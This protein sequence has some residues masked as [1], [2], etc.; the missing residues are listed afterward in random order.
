MK[1]YSDDAPIPVKLQE[2]P[3][4]ISARLGMAIPV[5]VVVAVAAAYSN[6]IWSPFVLDDLP[7]ITGNSSI[8]QW[9]TALAA[10]VQSSTQGRPALNLSFALNYWIS[11]YSVWSYHVLNLLIHTACALVLYGIVRRTL[12]RSLGAAAVPIAGSVALLWSVHPLNT[13]AVTYTVQRAESLMGLLMLLTVYCFIRFADGDSRRHWVFGV[14]SVVSCFLGMATKEVMVAAPLIVW[15]YDRAFVAGS[16]QSALRVRRGYYCSLAASWIVL[17]ILVFNGDGRGGTAGLGNGV[18]SWSYCITQA[19]AIVHYLRL[20]FYP[21]PLIFYYGEGLITD[22]LRVV[23]EAILLIGLLAATVLALRM[24]PALGFLGASFFLVLAPSSSFV[25]VV[26]ETAAEHRMYLALVPVV[27][28]GVLAIYR[29]FGSLGL[30]V[31]PALALCLGVMTHARNQAYDSALRLWSTTVRDDPGNP[32]AHNNLGCELDAI[33]GRTR[34]AMA[35]FETAIRLRPEH[36]E[37]H[38]NLANDLRLIPG[39]RNE[40]IAEFEA[41]L[42][43]NPDFPKAHNNLAAMLVGDPGRFGDSIHHYREAIRL[44]P[45]YAEAHFNLGNAW[46]MAQGRERDAVAEYTIALQLRPDYAEAHNN[47]SKILENNPA[48]QSEAIAHLVEAIRI[49]PGYTEAQYNLGTELSTIPGRT[50]EAIAHLREAIRLKSDYAEAR[51]NLA[52]LW[53]NIPEHWEEAIAQYRMA[54]EIQPGYPE[55]HYNLAAALLMRPGHEDEARSQLQAFLKLDP[56]NTQAQRLLESIGGPT[57][58]K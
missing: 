37:A 39:R 52:N 36:A 29:L 17:G 38:Y 35:E 32:W 33:P 28:L 30:L 24:S 22:P 51:N 23:P 6:T 13:E 8:R 2:P 50:D 27:V 41:A 16:F 15:L 25:P 46:S 49:N 47:L 4:R 11:G 5:L 20:C 10:P 7:S 44:Y 57:T 26:T 42:R 58:E 48:T 12:V 53:A 19:H 56:G 55:E 1:R 21:S 45:G 54:I 3:S 9:A 31:V 43:F 34:D 40:A 14:L 18:S